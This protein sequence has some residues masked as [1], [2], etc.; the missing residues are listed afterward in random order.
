[1]TWETNPASGGGGTFVGGPGGKK[2]VGFMGGVKNFMK[3]PMGLGMMAMGAG[4]L[5]SGL[6]PEGS[7]LQK[8]GDFLGGAGSGAM[9]GAM[10][11]NVVPVVGP[12]AGAIVGGLIGGIGSLLHEGGQVGKDGEEVNTVLQKGEF[13]TK[14]SAVKAIGPE[15]MATMNETGRVPS[16]SDPALAAAI[17]NLSSKM[18]ALIAK[19]APGDFIMEVDKREFGRIINGHFGTAGSSP[20]AGVK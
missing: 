7:G 16:G 8:A 2:K 10:L 3:S 18:D 19:I 20:A 9:T 1:M 12:V 13:V 14:K 6:A 17:N 5:V 4:S 11:G 15:N